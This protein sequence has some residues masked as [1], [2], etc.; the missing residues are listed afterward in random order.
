MLHLRQGF[1]IRSEIFENDQ[2]SVILTGYEN[3]LLGIATSKGDDMIASLYQ[4]MVTC[5]KL[6]VSQQYRF[7]KTSRSG[8]KVM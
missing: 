6:I 7:F 2:N 3:I 5:Q 1:G 8:D 4:I